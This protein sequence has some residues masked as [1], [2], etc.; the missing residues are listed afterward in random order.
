MKKSIEKNIKKIAQLHKLFFA[1]A[2]FFSV[3]FLF[4]FLVVIYQ[5]I[6]SNK[7]FIGISL[8]NV[9]LNGKTFNEAQYEITKKIDN[10]SNNGLLIIYEDKKIVLPASIVGDTPD[11]SLDIFNFNS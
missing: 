6:Y 8:A 10:F 5:N 2:I 9:E 4:I 11:L 7:F 1:G 3:I